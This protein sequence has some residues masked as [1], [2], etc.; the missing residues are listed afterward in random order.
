LKGT[1][2]FLLVVMLAACQ[3]ADAPLR[4]VPPTADQDPQLPQIEIIVAGHPR[5]IHLETFGNPAN[6][7][8]LIL[9]GSLGD[10]RVFLPYQVL[11]DRY[12]VVMWDQR[13]NGLSERIPK[14]EIGAP[15]VVE[16]IDR[17]KERFS[18]DRPVTLFGHSFGAM[19]AALYISARPQNV[20]QAILAEPAGLNAEGM[21]EA[22]KTSRNINI[23]DEKYVERSWQNAFLS[24][25][26]HEQLD[27]RGLTLLQGNET[28]YYCDQ[29]N[30]P[31][32]P[33]W[34]VGAYYDLV[35]VRKM[36]KGTR[37]DFDFAYGLKNFP[38]TVLP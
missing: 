10:Y 12:F 16:E 5:K 24:P 23:L 1:L 36:M 37:W 30:K 6:P 21:Q 33:N 31:D 27:Y 7:V 26:D 29:K 22:M 8:L 11:A 20:R 4:L 14:E 2:F 3:P 34:R 9:H 19:Y 25:S 17:V 18:P 28:L 13:G 35:R 32:W 38:G 15:Y